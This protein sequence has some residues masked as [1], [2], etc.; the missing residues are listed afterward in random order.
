MAL[1]AP[2]G[3][4]QVRT[5]PATLPVLIAAGSLR[6]AMNEIIHAYH[7]K[8]GILFN[9]KY[10]ASGKLINEIESGARV[11]VFASAFVDYPGRLAKKNLLEPSRIFTHDSLCVVAKPET[12]LADV[13][14]LETLRKPTVRLAT[15]TPISDP[16]GDYTW[17]F[18]KNADRQYPGIYRELDS[19][20]LMLSGTSTPMPGEELPYVVAFE[21][22]TADAYIMYCSS[23]VA[24]KQA[25]PGLVAVRIPEEYNVRS[26]YGIAA[27][28]NSDAGAKFISFVLSPE[29]QQIL[30]N[31]GF[32]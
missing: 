27:A 1:Q 4:A 20:A 18:F 21:E 25:L 13:N 30:K 29:G 22:D 26:D 12:Q 3:V 7:V 23:A 5:V 31:Y 6:N 32:N 8:N 24:T 14:I 9:S 10:G 28:L 17:Q 19:K 11:D 16:M 2:S 15:S